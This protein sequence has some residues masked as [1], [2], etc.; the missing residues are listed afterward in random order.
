[1][2]KPFEC[3]GEKR[4][5]AAAFRLLATRPAW[6]DTPVVAALAPVAGEL[7]DERDVGRLL[8]SD[9]DLR[10][11]DPQVADAVDALLAADR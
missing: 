10:F 2:D 11:A 4:E 5:S 7:V 6:R 3:V 1:V 9:D 8:D